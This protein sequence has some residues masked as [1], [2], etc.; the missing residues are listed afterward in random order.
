M[1]LLKI[2]AII[3][4]GVLALLGVFAFVLFALGYRPIIEPA[5]YPDW[6]AITAGA[7]WLGALAAIAIPVAIFVLD[8]RMKQRAEETKDTLLNE[9]KEFKV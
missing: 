8:K 5:A 4:V 1:K 7:E 3:V 9:L 2:L 6:N